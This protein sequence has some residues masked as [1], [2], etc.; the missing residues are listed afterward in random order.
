MGKQETG[1][2]NGQPVSY[3]QPV[4][5]AM[6]TARGQWNRRG[7]LTRTCR[8]A[9]AE[10]E[11][12]EHQRQLRLSSGKKNQTR[13]A[14]SFGPVQNHD[15]RDEKVPFQP[16]SRP[17]MIKF[18][19]NRQVVCRGCGLASAAGTLV[20]RSLGCARSAACAAAAP[21]SG[22]FRSI[23]GRAR[24]VSRAKL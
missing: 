6:R 2:Q 17:K 24:S 20:C 10:A 12:A 14:S 16:L 4:G 19:R 3:T 5:A 13:H 9:A 1:D 15:A 8:A 11:A 21:V 22:Q 23:S 18:G 7:Q